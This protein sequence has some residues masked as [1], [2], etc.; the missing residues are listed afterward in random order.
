LLVPFKGKIP[1]VEKAGF[2]AP[3]AHII[4]DV[5]L[6]QNS[7]VWFSSTIRGDIDPITIGNETNIQDNSVIHSDKGKPVTIGNYVTIGHGVI[8][9]GC[10]IKDRCLIGM[11]AIIMNGA[12]IGEECIIGAGTLIPEGK[13]IPPRS[14]VVS[15][16]KIINQVS[17]DQVGG[18]IRQAEIY[19]ERGKVYAQEESLKKG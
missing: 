15:V 16:A 14:V 3:G 13:K 18:I 5:T 10:A 19:A 9:H 2:I 8:L 17:D 6:G 7:S 4:G 1:K 12:E 11:G